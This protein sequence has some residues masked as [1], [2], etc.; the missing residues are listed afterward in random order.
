MKA[1]RNDKEGKFV[2]PDLIRHPPF[3][4]SASSGQT[5]QG[6]KVMSW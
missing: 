3:D 5:A 2:M 1:L 6:D 4:P